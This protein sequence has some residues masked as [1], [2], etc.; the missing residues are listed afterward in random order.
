MTKTPRIASAAAIIGTLAFPG[1]NALPS[2]AALLV[3]NTEGNNILLFVD[4]LPRRRRGIP[5]HRYLGF[6]FLAPGLTDLLC[7]AL[8]VAPQ[9]DT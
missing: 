1:V 3:G 2:Q 8:M 7:S 9:I 6:C 4:I 5:K